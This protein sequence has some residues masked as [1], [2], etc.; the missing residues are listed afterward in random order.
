MF[1]G[2]RSVLEK[3]TDR[4]T[5]YHVD[6]TFGVLPGH[7]DVLK[8]RSS[9]VLNICADYGGALVCVM[10][11]VMSCRKVGLYRKIF[12]F[13]KEQFPFFEPRAF[14]AD[15]ETGLRKTL[16]ETWPN[17]RLVGCR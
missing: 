13:I 2:D 1:L 12:R 7:L 16:E 9:Q 15:W 14:M 8:V 11:V 5:F 6:A 10:T 17:A 3:A 4:A